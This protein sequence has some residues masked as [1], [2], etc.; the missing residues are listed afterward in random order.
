MLKKT[1]TMH[2]RLED[3]SLAKHDLFESLDLKLKTNVYKYM[4]FLYYIFNTYIFVLLD[5]LHTVS[6]YYNQE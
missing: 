3:K 6:L 4:F 1:I 2:L 5:V